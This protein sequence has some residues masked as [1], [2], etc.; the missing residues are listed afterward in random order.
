MHYGIDDEYK[1][2]GILK[3]GVAIGTF[4]FEEDPSQKHVGV[5]KGV[6]TLNWYLDKFG[7]IHF[8]DLESSSD[9]YR[10]NQYVSTW[11]RYG[12][13]KSKIANWG[14]FRIPFS[15][16]LDI[17]AGEFSINPKYL[18]NGWNHR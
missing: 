18:G 13:K 11:T 12:T 10:N 2:K 6:M 15:G 17:G 16:D 7:T 8:D 5:F 9:N 14:E 3:Q 1:N 4:R